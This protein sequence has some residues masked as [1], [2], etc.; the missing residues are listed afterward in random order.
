[1]NSACY[2]GVIAGLTAGIAIG[3]MSALLD[4]S[5]RNSLVAQR[6]LSDTDTMIVGATMQLGGAIGAL[7]SFEASDRIGRRPT[8]AAAAIGFAVGSAI[9]ALGTLGAVVAGRAVIG[10]GTGALCATAPTY[11]NE[12]AVAKYRGAMDALFQVFTN[13]GILVAY[14]LNVWLASFPDGMYY[15]LGMP[16]PFAL[17]LLCGVEMAPES[18]R[19]MYASGAGDAG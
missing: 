6:G 2:I 16:I 11:I 9:A 19:W 13:L 10:L 12:V 7:F 15:S 5:N 18:P 4:D 1:M 17:A 3:N 8:M 14:A